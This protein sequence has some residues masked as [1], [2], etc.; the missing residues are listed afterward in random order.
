M[1]VKKRIHVL[2]ITVTF[3][4]PCTLTH[5]AREVGDCIH[6]EFYPTQR[7]D[8]DPGTFRVGKITRLNRRYSI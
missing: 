3:D 6:G 2:K 8:K 4:K 1:T 5:A 7:E